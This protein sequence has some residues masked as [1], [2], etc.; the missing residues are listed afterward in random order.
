MWPISKAYGGYYYSPVQALVFD[1][2][3]QTL[4]SDSARRKIALAALVEA[5]SRAAAS[6][7]HTAQPFQPTESSA[8]YIIEAWLRDPWMLV[9]GSVT[10]IASRAANI[11][12]RGV[13]GDFTKT[14][15]HLQA[16]DLVF[17]D[18]PYSGVHYSRFYHVLETIT[19][20]TEFEPV[21]RGRYPALEDRP[22]SMFSKKSGAV[23]AALELLKSCAEKNLSLVLTF[24][25]GGASNGLKASDFIAMG[26][27]LFPKIQ[28]E[29]V[30]TDFSTLGGNKKHR[31]A[32]KLCGESVISF[33]P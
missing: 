18:P 27:S 31:E 14:I 25:T 21:G 28:I 3:R 26:A 16:G 22:S 6:P 19:R 5:T 13:V 20:G 32:R 30:L 7:G 4:P 8:K 12:G 17:A 29:E 2:L 33:L 15:S 1:S 9:K 11:A 23:S 10:E 24:P